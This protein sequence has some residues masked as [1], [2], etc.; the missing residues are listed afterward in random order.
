MISNSG[1]GTLTLRRV[2]M[3]A[4]R[5]TTTQPIVFDAITM[6]AASEIYT[7]A[8]LQITGAGVVQGTILTTASSVPIVIDTPLTSPALLVSSATQAGCTFT[9]DMR[10]SGACT[11]SLTSL[12]VLNTFQYSGANAALS[13]SQGTLNG[14]NTAIT[15]T[16]GAISMYYHTLPPLSFIAVVLTRV[17]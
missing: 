8:S 16:S 13:I 3:N 5:F 10:G 17:G 14:P 7:G 11:L 1:T 4:H 12:T 2:V 15:T 6:S 9:G